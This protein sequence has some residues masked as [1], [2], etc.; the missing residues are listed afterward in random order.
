MQSGEHLPQILEERACAGDLRSQILCRGR[1]DIRNGF[2][3]GIAIPEIFAQA[4]GPRAKG[5]AARDLIITEK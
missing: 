1:R 4:C 2:L 3:H 5:N